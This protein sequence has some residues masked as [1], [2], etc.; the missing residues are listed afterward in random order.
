VAAAEKSRMLEQRRREMVEQLNLQLEAQEA[1]RRKEIVVGRPIRA[2]AA[3][4]A[5]A[6]WLTMMRD[7]LVLPRARR[8]TTG[9]EVG[10]F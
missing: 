3:A 8:T 1:R 7:H 5:A 10:R 6:A 4:A 9:L 2:A